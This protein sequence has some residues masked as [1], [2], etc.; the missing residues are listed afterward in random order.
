MALPNDVR[1]R[2]FRKFEEDSD[3]EVT[4]RTSEKEL[5]PTNTKKNNP[6]IALTYTGDNLTKITKTIDGTDYE[7]TLSY[8]GSTLDS[9]SEWVE[10]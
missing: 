2:E 10:V 3:G 4:L 6:S 1:D 5:V 7:K 9:V 8:T